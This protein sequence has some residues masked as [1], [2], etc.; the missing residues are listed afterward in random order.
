MNRATDLIPFWRRLQ[1]AS[2]RVLLLDYDGTLA[3]FR[4]KRDEAV[5]Y[6]GVRELIEEI[7]ARGNTRLI[8][9]SGRS[10]GDLLPLL[11]LG[12]SPEIWG[13]HG[14]ER[15]L[16]GGEPELGKLPPKALSALG[17]ARQWALDHGYSA[18][19][20]Y[21]PAS[22]ALHWRGC[23]PS[24]R[25]SMRQKAKVAWEEL[26]A[27]GGLELHPFDGGFELRCPGRDKGSVVRQ[28][29]SETGPDAAIAYLGDDL[30]DEDAFRALKGRGLTVL[31]RTKFRPSAADHWLQPPG[32]LLDFF[33]NWLNRS[34]TL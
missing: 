2:Q 34:G 23:S 20:E 16:P 1:S 7:L 22:V 24:L 30:T 5:P 26:A 6:P 25:A 29:L 21:K 19:L 3:P 11:G 18:H 31:V 27:S 8:I 4:V 33:Q 10:T 9:V 28:V 32:E 13:G 15:L 14:W 17:A 12:R